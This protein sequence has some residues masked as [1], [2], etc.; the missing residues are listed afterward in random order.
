[1]AYKNDIFRS[2]TSAIIT[3]T[4]LKTPAVLGRLIND[5]YSAGTISLQEKTEFINNGGYSAASG[6][7]SAVHQHINGDKGEKTYRISRALK[8]LEETIPEIVQKMREG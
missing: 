7:I 4:S 5:F 6:L 2:Y 8:I 1:M 3:E